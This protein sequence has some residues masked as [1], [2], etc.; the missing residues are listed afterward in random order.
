MSSEKRGR[1][2]EGEGEEDLYDPR[3]EDDYYNWEISQKSKGESEGEGKEDVYDPTASHS[4]YGTW[5]ISR[6]G[7]GKG[8]DSYAHIKHATRRHISSKDS[9]S[10]PY[11]PQKKKPIFP[12]YE[13][14]LFAHPDKNVFAYVTLLT[15]SIILPGR[16]KSDNIPPINIDKIPV[17]AGMSII[18]KNLSICGFVAP[19]NVLFQ[20]S[21]R[22]YMADL[23]ENGIEQCYP[24][25]ASTVRFLL[26]NEKA[27]GFKKSIEEYTKSFKDLEY[28]EAA[29]LTHRTQSGKFGYIT[30]TEN[31]IDETCNV[32]SGKNYYVNKRYAREQSKEI[33]SKRGIYSLYIT[34]VI[35]KSP[36]YVKIGPF[37]LLDYNS[38]EELFSYFRSSNPELKESFLRLLHKP[39][40]KITTKDL[41]NLFVI[42]NVNNAYIIDSGCAPI[43]PDET[44]EII[45]PQNVG[46]GGK[47]RK[48]KKRK[49]KKR[50][51]KKRIYIYR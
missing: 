23:L 24:T 20:H 36:K 51:T 12:F 48:T 21:A 42:C 27:P 33:V 10:L 11:F 43:S 37:D 8:L 15:H 7:Y 47:K 40:P 32:I 28:V 50:K 41:F 44:T 18:K 39:V 4:D 6:E 45:L 34:L 2:D 19:S 26:E 22:E 9:I 5:K 3:E 30:S 29:D 17:P 49:T 14:E 35:R 25:K 38:I 1:E 31:F 13:K 16:D 46:Y